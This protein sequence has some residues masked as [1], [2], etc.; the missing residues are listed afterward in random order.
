MFRVMTGWSVLVQV[1]LGTSVLGAMFSP[2]A[3][4]PIRQLL[5]QHQH[6]L[7]S[8]D[9]FSRDTVAFVFGPASARREDALKTL[10]SIV[11]DPAYWQDQPLIPVSSAFAQDILAKGRQATGA[12]WHE[13]ARNSTLTSLVQSAHDKQ[14]SYAPLTALE[15][16]A[17]RVHQRCIVLAKLFEQELPLVPPPVPTSGQG[18][19]RPV[20]MPD[21]YPAEQQVGLKRGWSSLTTAIREGDQEQITE[22][23]AQLRL[24]L[25]NLNPDAYAAAGRRGNADAGW[26]VALLSCMSGLLV[27]GFSRWRN[28]RQPTLG[29]RAGP[30]PV[31][32]TPKGCPALHGVPLEVP[33]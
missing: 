33:A 5:I 29:T 7:A 4:H 9:D 28:T 24:I 6:H 13:L 18:T 30:E 31:V 27:L 22:A 25:H 14:R 16:E 8:L 20:L 2:D 26:L 1:A 21:G 11:A 3:L 23:A 32:A 15:R 10:L 12:S 19:W 17:L